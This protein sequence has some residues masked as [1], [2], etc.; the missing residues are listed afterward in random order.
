MHKY[1]N[2]FTVFTVS[3]RPDGTISLQFTKYDEVKDLDIF[4]IPNSTEEIFPRNSE[5]NASVFLESHEEM[6]L[7]C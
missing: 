3:I 5:A 6:F 4:Q 2:V 7:V 1:K